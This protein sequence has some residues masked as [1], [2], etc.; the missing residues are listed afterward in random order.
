MIEIANG[1]LII[2]FKIL[3]LVGIGLNQASLILYALPF[4]LKIP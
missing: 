1:S 2:N 4:L 3:I